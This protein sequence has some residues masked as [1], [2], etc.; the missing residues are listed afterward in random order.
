MQ[1]RLERLINLINKTGDKLIVFDPS[2]P[3][4]AY[5]IMGV[6]EYEKLAKTSGAVKRLTEDELIDKINRD[7]ALWKEGQDYALADDVQITDYDDERSEPVPVSVPD[8]PERPVR[9]NHWSI[10]AS[11][12]REAADQG[13]DIKS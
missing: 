6:S 4:A 12:R 10:P 2:N 13:S 5:A 3:D 1:D 9:K 8:E 7:I 11:R